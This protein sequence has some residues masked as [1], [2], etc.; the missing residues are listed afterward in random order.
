MR[1]VKAEG[2]ASKSDRA[3]VAAGSVAQA[4]AAL[5]EKRIE[6]VAELGG[7]SAQASRNGDGL[8]ESTA[9]AEEK[10]G[11]RVLY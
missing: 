7:G 8:G 3:K 1:V 6:G 9:N 11:K 5:E 2:T 4:N 10:A